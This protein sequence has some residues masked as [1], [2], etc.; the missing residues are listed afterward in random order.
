[1]AKITDLVASMAAPIVEGAG[2]SLWDVE[3]VREAGE[4]FLRVYIDKEGGVSIDDCE[5]VSRGVDPLLDEADL[6]SQSYYLEVWSAG[7]NRT[8]ERDFHFTQ[9]IGQKVTVGLFKPWGEGGEKEP[10]CILKE[11]RGK[12]IVVEDAAGKEHELTLSELRFVRRFDE[13]PF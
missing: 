9:N 6:I 5:A 8:L 11:Y 3:Y 7:M 4:W 10:V 13:L 2:C 1:M 12:T